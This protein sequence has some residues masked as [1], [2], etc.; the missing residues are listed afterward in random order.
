MV[1]KDEKKIEKPAK[2]KAELTDEQ[3]K[4]VNGGGMMGGPKAGTQP[5]VTGN[6]KLGS[7][8]Q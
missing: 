7:T 6:T 2:S 4:D 8:G 3:L 1:N 5:V